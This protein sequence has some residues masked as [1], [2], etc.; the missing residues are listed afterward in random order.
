[1]SKMLVRWLFVEEILADFI[2]YVCF[3]AA[4]TPAAAE[5]P[6]FFYAPTNLYQIFA[7]RVL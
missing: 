3:F 2:F 5:S 1:M 7:K 4:L 6:P